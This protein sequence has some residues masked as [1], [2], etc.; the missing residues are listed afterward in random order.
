MNHNDKVKVLNKTWT[1]AY[2]NRVHSFLAHQSKIYT[3]IAHWKKKK[4]NF[5]K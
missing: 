2:H 1:L 4:K 5:C 3:K